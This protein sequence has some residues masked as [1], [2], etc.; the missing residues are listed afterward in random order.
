VVNDPLPSLIFMQHLEVQVTAEIMTF[1][2]YAYDSRF[3]GYASIHMCFFSVRQS[4]S[5]AIV[6]APFGKAHPRR[7]VLGLVC[8]SHMHSAADV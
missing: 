7:R 6:L 2:F 3:G 1:F 4:N 5:E 8:E